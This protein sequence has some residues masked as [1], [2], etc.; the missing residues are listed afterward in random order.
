MLMGLSLSFSLAAVWTWMTRAALLSREPGQPG[1]RS[2]PTWPLSP[3]PV[4][5]AGRGSPD[6]THV[7]FLPTL[8]PLILFSI[9]FNKWME[10]LLRMLK[11]WGTRNDGKDTQYLSTLK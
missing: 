1:P 6:T 2:C 8:P 4:T 3:P 11:V 5:A 10:D 9:L 7:P